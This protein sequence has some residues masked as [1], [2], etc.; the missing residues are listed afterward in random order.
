MFRFELR[1]LK[2]ILYDYLYGY[3]LGIKGNLMSKFI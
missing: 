3:I 2:Y 1:I